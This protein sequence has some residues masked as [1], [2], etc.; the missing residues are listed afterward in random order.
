MVWPSDMD[1]ANRRQLEAVIGLGERSI[2]KSYYPELRRRLNEL[3]RFR[4]LLNQIGE[5]IFVLSLPD[6]RIVDINGT[7]LQLMRCDRAEIIGREFSDLLAPE[8]RV[9][10]DEAF[11]ADETED[12]AP[13][14]TIQTRLTGCGCCDIMVELSLRR[15]RYHAT[16]YGVVVA[17]DIRRQIEAEQNA[18]NAHQR[19]IDAIESLPDAFAIYD[20]EDR[21]V[22]YN[23]RYP[24]TY[25]ASRAAIA[26]G[27][28]F[29]AI[30]KEGLANGQYPE[31]VGREEEW[32]AERLAKHRN[33]HGAVEQPLP[34]GRWVLVRERRTQNG[35]TVGERTDITE[36]KRREHDLIAAKRRIEDQAN[37]LRRLAEDLRQA[38][39][40]AEAAR[41]AAER[42]SRAKSEFL[43]M[44]SHELRTPLNAIIGFSDMMVSRCFGALGDAHY[45]DYAVSIR[46]SGQHL[47]SIINS[48]LD[49]A[50]M[51][52]GKYELREELVA[53]GDVVA[54]SLVL[55]QPTAA[56]RNVTMV[57]CIDPA[58]P[59]LLAD[60]GLIDLIVTNLVSN[61]VKFTRG[62]GR[63]AVAARRSLGGG[64]DLVVADTGIGMAP[65]DVPKAF[66]P[67]E[68]LDQS[69]ARCY[70]GTG[71]GLPLA[72]FSAELHDAGIDIESRVGEG[73]RITV[74]FPSDRVSAA[75]S[76]A[77]PEPKTLNGEAVDVCPGHPHPCT[78]DHIMDWQ[79]PCATHRHR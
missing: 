73:T 11:G 62:G 49:L 37:D 74:S 65:E 15:R 70:P 38:H 44:M 54:G 33:P 2:K 58:L 71:L 24:E 27:Q 48:I 75:L 36:L 34:D 35:E 57:R 41:Q 6:C 26:P 28:P 68:Q 5:M 66:R 59:A 67:F 55:L 76:A 9:D 40:R 1:D 25:A 60:R 13:P 43:A 14:T 20:A 3:E 42:A 16:R 46:D 17:R 47:L 56:E 53:L 39:D 8:L 51:E 10:L 45:G 12:D 29:I 79:A 61:A 23:S 64:I 78:L 7:V 22:V 32:L 30:L 4:G 31:A 52:V 72:Q 18:R 50:K 69:V 21:L 63:V 77:G 19:L